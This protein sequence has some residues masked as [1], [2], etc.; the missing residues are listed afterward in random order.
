MRLNNGKNL[1]LVL[2]VIGCFLAHTSDSGRSCRTSC[3]KFPF[4]ALYQFFLRCRVAIP[5][6][7]WLRETEK[8]WCHFF[9]CIIAA[10]SEARPLYAMNL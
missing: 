9:N 5:V 4:F 3:Y 8:K 7:E 1:L 6:G 2:V 10:V